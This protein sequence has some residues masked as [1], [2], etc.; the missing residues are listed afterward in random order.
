MFPRRQ[1]INVNI[2]MPTTNIDHVVEHRRGRPGDGRSL[3]DPE[4]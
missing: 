2:Q 1:D 3:S 4:A